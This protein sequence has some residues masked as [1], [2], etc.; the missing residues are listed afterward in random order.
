M[1]F[2]AGVPIDIEKSTPSMAN[3]KPPVLIT[4]D[5]FEKHVHSLERNL[6]HIYCELVYVAQPVLSFNHIFRG[7]SV[8]RCSECGLYYRAYTSYGKFFAV[9]YS[10]FERKLIMYY[11][12]RIKFIY[13]VKKRIFVNHISFLLRN[14]LI[15]R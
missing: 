15:W 11:N 14:K 7:R 2:H 1:P 9:K 5:K 8:Y 10:S 12:K 6:N 3:G 4:R 13:Y